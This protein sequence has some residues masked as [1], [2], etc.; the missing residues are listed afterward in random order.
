LKAALSLDLGKNKVFSDR[1]CTPN[2]V[3]LRGCIDL[4]IF[5][6]ETKDYPRLSIRQSHDN[7][8]FAI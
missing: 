1:F 3:R 4:E 6:E 5:T 2:A 8:R 7:N